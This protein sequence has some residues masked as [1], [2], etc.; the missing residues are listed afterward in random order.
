MGLAFFD[1]EFAHTG[2][3]S[4]A[5]VTGWAAI[6]LPLGMVDGLPAGVQLMG[7]SEAVLLRLAR[8][9]EQATPWA[10]RPP[11]IS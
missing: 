9:L 3:T 4:V 7:P 8:Q 1:T 6:T 5:N 2:W 11:A 10:L